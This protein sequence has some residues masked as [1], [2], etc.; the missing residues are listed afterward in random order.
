MSFMDSQDQSPPTVLPYAPQQPAT[1]KRIV[2]WVRIT[3]IVA[4]LNLT[5]TVGYRAVLAPA[6]WQLSDMWGMGRI[7]SRPMP[8][9]AAPYAH[10][11][12]VL[13]PTS[14]WLAIVTALSA[15]VVVSIC[16]SRENRSLALWAWAAGLMAG[17]SGYLGLE[18]SLMLGGF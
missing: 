15:I 16:H 8:A 2:L 11:G 9:R 7:V 3:A 6:G 17:A 14:R 5:L 18:V 1:S 4:A 13:G 12:L 10:A